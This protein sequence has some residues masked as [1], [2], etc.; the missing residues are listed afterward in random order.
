MN[1]D[2]KKL[3]KGLGAL[4]SSSKNT[5]E[6]ANKLNISQIYPNKN[7]PRKNFDDKEIN[8]LALSIKTQGLLQPIIVRF[9]EKDKYEIIAGERRWRASQLAGLHEIECVVKDLPDDIVFEAALI[10]NIQREDLNAIEEAGAYK[11]LIEL[12]KI[13]N[14][15]LAKQIGKSASHV[16]NML[17]LLELDIEIQDMIISGQLS[18]GHARALIGVPDALSIAKNIIDKKLSVRDVERKTSKFKKS[19]TQK[20]KDANILDLERELSAKI[21]LKTSIHFNEG[22]S[23]GSLTLYY[24]DLNQLDEIMKR[25]KK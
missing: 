22:G 21:G 24:S 11:K 16:S 9:V 14:D 12:K 25:L 1:K 6:S 15:G 4:L 20:G 3:G 13:T 2:N 10:E 7:Q 18:M 17:R 19:K 8:Q 5:N 23:S